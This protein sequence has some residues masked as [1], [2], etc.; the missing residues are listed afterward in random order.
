MYFRNPLFGSPFGA[1]WGYDARQGGRHGAGH[2][3][4]YLQRMATLSR[5]N[6][7]YPRLARSQQLNSKE[8]SVASAQNKQASQHF[9]LTCVQQWLIR[10]PSCRKPPLAGWASI[11]NMGG[12]ITDLNWNIYANTSPG[13]G[14]GSSMGF[15][16]WRS[17]QYRNQNTGPCIDTQAIDP[18]PTLPCDYAPPASTLPVGYIYIYIYMYIYICIYTYIY[19]YIYIYTH[20]HIH[21]LY[22][23]MCIYIYI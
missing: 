23:C 16:P 2:S 1:R 10:R 12:V 22:I 15:G 17:K 20:R 19:M 7:L 13:A 6:S 3:T 9:F 4:G 8:T 21:T 14:S 18:R 5:A 11:T